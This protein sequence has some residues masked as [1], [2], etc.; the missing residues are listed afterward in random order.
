MR[1]RILNSLD[2]LALVRWLE[3]DVEGLILDGLE[4]GRVEGEPFGRGLESG[5]SP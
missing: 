4:E 3:V 2:K 5:A 1:Y